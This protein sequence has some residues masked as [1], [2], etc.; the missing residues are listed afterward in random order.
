MGKEVEDTTAEMFKGNAGDGGD[1]GDGSAGNDTGDNSKAADADLTSQAGQ[2][3]EMLDMF[4]GEDDHSDDGKDKTDN[5][6]K[7]PEDKKTSEELG[8]DGKDGEKSKEPTEPSPQDKRIQELEAKIN[9]LTSL[10]KQPA[11]EEKGKEGSADSNEGEQ[12]YFK[13]RL[14]EAQKDLAAEY[15]SDDEYEEVFEKREKLNEVLKKVQ[16]DTL[17]GVF[18]SIPR[19]IATL[20]PHHITFYNKTAEFYKNNPDLYQHRKVVGELIDEAAAKN[21]SWNLDTLL[22]FVG[23]KANDVSD[24]G[25][26]R[27]KLGLKRQAI[28]A[29]EKD[30]VRRPS[31]AKPSYSKRMEPDVKLTGLQKEINDVI[32][33]MEE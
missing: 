19:I 3:S 9:E 4:V 10:L 29:A 30:N 26:L 7:E 21:P 33:S 5:T 27:K 14:E 11:K 12:E 20:I 15:V 16:N 28:K 18:R 8:E 23:G 6:D 13:Q 31:F 1:A 25:E 2:I 22:E 24:V 17:Q 32:S